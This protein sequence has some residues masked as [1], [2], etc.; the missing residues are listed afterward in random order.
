MRRSVTAMICGLIGSLFSLFWG[1]IFGVGGDL[2]KIIPTD[3]ATKL[4]T[5]FTVLGWLAFIGGIVGIVG[6]ALSLKKARKGAICL[7]V[8]TV[9]SGALQLYI[10]G[11]VVGGSGSSIMTF[12]IIFLLPTVLLVVAS[13]FAWLAK[14]TEP[15][16]SASAAN[17]TNSGNQ[18]L[19]KELSG[20]KEMLDKGIITEEEFAVAKKNL[21]EK[22]TK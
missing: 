1:F 15:S 8:A 11:K 16:R 22:Y 3:E 2:F 9:L 14:E 4:A 21:L 7:T 10:F 19:E 13:V 6:S 12:I 18:G 17:Q 5:T 20:L